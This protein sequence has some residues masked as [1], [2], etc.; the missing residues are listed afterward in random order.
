L[1]YQWRLALS[2]P[3]KVKTSWTAR[4]YLQGRRNEFV[5]REKKD[6]PTEVKTYGMYFGQENQELFS[7]G[8]EMLILDEYSIWRFQKPQVTTTM[9]CLVRTPRM[10]PTVSNQER[11]AV[12]FDK[13]KPLQTSQNFAG[14]VLPADLLP[15]SPYNEFLRYLQSLNTPVLLQSS[16]PYTDIHGVNFN[17]VD[18][19]IFEN[20]CIHSD[21]E[22][23]DFFQAMEL[24]QGL[25]RA[26]R[27]RETRKFFVGFHDLWESRPEPAIIRRAFKFA[28]FYN[29]CLQVGP[30][31]SLSNIEECVPV[32]MCLSGF[33]WLKRDDVL[34]L[35]K[36]WVEQPPID[37]QGTSDLEALANV[38]P[39]V[40]QAFELQKLIED[41]ESYFFPDLNE[42]PPTN[43]LKDAPQRKSLWATTSLN[44][45]LCTLGCYDLGEEV[46][47]EHFDAVV[48]TQEHLKDIDMLHPIDTHA[49][50]IAYRRYLASASHNV[51]IIKPLIDGLVDG[52]I[53]VYHG[54]DTGFAVPDHE[55]RIWSVSRQ[56]NSK[57]T[58]Y[59]S[60]RAPDFNG[61]LFH[62]YLAAVG[63]PR[64]HRF[65]F[66]TDLAQ[67]LDPYAPN[68]PP[69]VIAELRNNT[70]AELLSLIAQIQVSPKSAFTELVQ[71]MC[72]DLLVRDASRLNW[73][74]YHSRSLLKG[75]VSPW[76][77]LDTRLTW[78]K[79]KGAT[80]VPRIARLERLYG[81]VD[82]VILDALYDIDRQTIET[83]TTVLKDLMSQPMTMS[84]DLLLLMVF[85]AFRKYGFEDVYLE[86]TDRCPLFHQQPDQAG[87]FAELWV[88]GSQ[89]EV[90]FDITPRALGDIIY[91]KYRN[92]L[93]RNPP[94]VE[95]WNGVD[96]FTAFMRV[97]NPIAETM[98][99]PPK[100]WR[101]KFKKKDTLKG[102]KKYGY[103]SIFC[104]PAIVD[105]SMLTFLGRGLYLTAFM[106][107][108]ETLMGTYA[109]LIALLLCAGVTGWVGSGGGFYLFNVSCSLILSCHR[110]SHQA[111]VCV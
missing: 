22:R 32:E 23:R 42:I 85:C 48:R 79:R 69:R 104:I 21:G 14:L 64:E 68:L 53:T 17:F 29:T 10:D 11:L 39:G 1:L 86:A 81:I 40:T 50:I 82:G 24:R 80:E 94:P 38:I 90:Y 49:S 110:S 28:K 12:V 101:A 47:Q 99:E 61:T 111:I 100:G 31:K 52:T 25:G 45:V 103:L 9:L 18:G 34:T 106:G 56:I 97:E 74:E 72:H 46:L 27:Q 63:L 3:K 70:Y 109:L 96:L 55:A 87:V 33:D 44:D 6:F 71:N 65:Q 13:V 93:K 20:A 30:T 92:Y 66:E 105:V 83:I 102:I 89:C 73:R 8:F 54:L 7:K 35:H 36:K 19:V 67:A 95:S 62:T 15:K 16:P 37:F 98:A 51:E 78:Y 77:V 58:I 60:Q 26:A 108:I 76:E 88:L 91:Y 57:I 84:G 5:V 41:D 2:K 59:I 107:D 4:A 75:D 43:Y